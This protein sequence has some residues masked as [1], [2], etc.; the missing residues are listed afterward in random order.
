MNNNIVRTGFVLKNEI[1]QKL[2][3][4]YHGNMVD[5]LLTANNQITIGNTTIKLAKEFGFCY[6][7][8]RAIDYTYETL[9]KFP[10]KTIY[11]TG[12]MIHNPL[13]NENLFERGIK[14]LSGKYHSGEVI[15]DIQKE[16]VV[17][18][19]AFGVSTSMLEQLKS[20]DCIMVDTTCGSVILVWKH[21]KKFSSEGFTALIH[22]KYYHE[23]TIATAS[24]AVNGKY[25]IIKDLE[26][27][28]I[29]CDFILNQKYK[30]EFLEKFKNAYSNDFNPE[31]DLQKI[32]V[33]NQTTM[34]SGE[35]LQVAKKIEDALIQRHGKDDIEKHFRSFDTICSATQD[36][37]DAIIELLETAPDL[38][39]VIG[40]F[41]S[42]N[43]INLN[44]IASQ[45]G[46]S[47]H[48]TNAE[49]IIDEN[50][51][52][53]KPDA[54]SKTITTNNWLPQTELTVAI[55]AGA[56]TPNNVSSEVIEKVLEL[57]QKL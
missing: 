41:N 43:T 9:H 21:V 27:T 5:K 47:Y 18:L 53:H 39:L 23:E 11:L 42:S 28:Q 35:S 31:K 14:F 52:Q 34:L 44:N 38:S 45:Y 7:V 4:E 49:C 33:A 15:E 30:N 8:D 55:T 22:G 29:V 10:D 13:V 25:I 16:D 46:P 57:R 50:S 17:I 2:N 12:E 32:G 6:G 26:E 48:I 3:D 37:Q 51:I 56:S 36:R 54:G 19:P 24:Y 1:A 20:R 40:G